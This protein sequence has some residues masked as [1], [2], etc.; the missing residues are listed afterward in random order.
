[1]LH[2]LAGP[3]AK[4]AQDAYGISYIQVCSQHGPHNSSKYALKVTY[5]D[6]WLV[7][8]CNVLVG[9]GLHANRIYILLTKAL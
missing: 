7:H 6:F 4:L 5:I 2:F 9:N 1:M 3:G 8:I